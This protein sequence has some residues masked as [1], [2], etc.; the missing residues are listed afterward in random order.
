MKFPFF[1][2]RFVLGT[3]ALAG[4]F[5]CAPAF[6]LSFPAEPHLGQEDPP[7]RV[8]RV[9][10]GRLLMKVVAHASGKEPIQLARF[11]VQVRIEGE[12]Q[13]S[14][15]LAPPQVESNQVFSVGLQ[16]ALPKGA[17]VQLEV[18]NLKDR[19]LLFPPS[20]CHVT[21]IVQTEPVAFPWP[22]PPASAELRVGLAASSG[23]PL[24]MSDLTEDLERALELKGYARRSYYP[25]PGGFALLTPLEQI[26]DKGRPIE[27]ESRFSVEMPFLDELGWIEQAIGLFFR[28]PVG[29]YRGLVFLVTDQAWSRTALAPALPGFKAAFDGGWNA[30]PHALG[31]LPVGAKVAMTI[32]IYEFTRSPQ[33]QGAVFVA[34]SNLGA[35]EHLRVAGI[36]DQLRFVRW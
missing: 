29:R 25:V 18:R 28:T 2:A 11:Q 16:D 27:G 22:P 31:A 6:T 4:G 23:R 9:R 8:G 12:P 34:N 26:D 10:D 13:A 33:A 20:T 30:L 5:G 15:V 1:R 32:L 21:E 36:V 24:R 17:R 35:R 19:K 3:F 14:G 7:C